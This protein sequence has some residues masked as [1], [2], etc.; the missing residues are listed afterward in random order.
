[1]IR[2]T[3][4]LALVLLLVAPA[5]VDAQ[6]RPAARLG[7]ASQ[8]AWVRG[9]SAFVMRLDVD[10][11]RAPQ[12]LDL[13]VTVHRAA[14]SRS[15]FVRTIDGELLGA[16]VHSDRV[17]FGTLRF[18]P[19]GAI[20]LRIDLP[21]LRTGVYPVSV[22]LVDNETDD[23][24]ASLVTHLVKV[25]AEDVE[26][27]LAV[28]WVQPY[29]ADPALQPSGNVSLPDS[30][31]DQLRA[32]ASQLGGDV[33]MTVAPTPETIAALATLDDGR[34][35]AALAALLTRHQVVSSPFVDLD[36]S[37]LVAADRVEDVARQRTEGDRALDEVLGITGDNRSWATNGVVTADAIDALDEL[38]VR[39][40]ILDDDTLEPLSSSA[41]GGLTLTRPF[42]VAGSGATEL[43]AFVVDAG[44]VAHFDRRD[45]VLAAHL[46]LADLAVLHQDLPGLAR[47]VV[48]RPPLEWEPSDVFL[49][50]VL[51]NLSTS[52]LLRPVTLSE[53]FDGVDPLLDDEDEPVVRELADA[54]PQSLGFNPGAV[55]RARDA[56]AA[57]ES[58]LVL[59]S[60]ANLDLLDRL[61]LVAQSSDLSPPVRRDYIAGVTASIA[62]ATSK[63]RVLGDRT[64]R[65][66]AR[67]GTIPLTLVNDND[68][69]VRVE[70]ELASDKLTFTDSGTEGRPERRQLVLR[71]NSTT[72]EAV[73]VK[74]RTSGTFSMRVT[75]R[76][77]DGRLQ[78]GASR[79][80]I[81]STVASG[82]GVLLSVGAAAF[83]LLWWA[84]HWR[85]VRRSRRLVPA[86]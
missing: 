67:E 74:A 53:L 44:L 19:G 32:V 21:E 81:T 64:Y 40:V 46:L 15:Q 54:E 4:L 38:G 22:A 68:Y 86:E 18:D 59:R 85:T 83:L 57:F 29:G 16:S 82:I 33:P 56:M 75:L 62:D 3:L 14:R 26:V 58:L 5:R 72:T 31:L 23:V 42:R 30:A 80:T 60:S 43:D 84:R 41:T 47:G 73:P 50:T 25:P 76:S 48:V 2:R 37:A 79:F 49:S 9:S 10:A 66:T 24:V 20:S 55:E 36:L 1:M 28:A 45:P 69:D 71:A 8:T 65:L 78:L 61:L 35:V 13:E 51:L 12:R 6:T 27:P 17:P 11:V 39:R 34:T 7:L 63:V 70:V 52:P 77:P